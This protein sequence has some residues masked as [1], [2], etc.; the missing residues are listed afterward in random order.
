MQIAFSYYQEDQE[1][2]V[3]DSYDVYRIDGDGYLG[4]QIFQ[5]W[6]FNQNI[7]YIL[8]IGVIVKGRGYFYCIYKFWFF[9]IY[10]SVND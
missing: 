5:F 2:I 7:L 9:Y 6:N 8:W 1:D 4:V 3:Y 10:Y